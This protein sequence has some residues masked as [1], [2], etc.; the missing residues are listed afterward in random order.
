[1]DRHAMCLHLSMSNKNADYIN[2]Q[3]LVINGLDEVLARSPI[4]NP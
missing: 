3:S 4:R 1:M 2:I